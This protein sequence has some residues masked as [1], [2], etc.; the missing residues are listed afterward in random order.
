MCRRICVWHSVEPVRAKEMALQILKINFFW[1]LKIKFSCR[2]GRLTETCNFHRRLFVWCGFLTHDILFHGNKFPNPHDH[3]HCP[4]SLRHIVPYYRLK[5]YD[6][7]CFNCKCKC[8]F[9]RII[10]KLKIWIFGLYTHDKNL[11]LFFPVKK[12]KFR[13]QLPRHQIYYKKWD[14]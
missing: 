3:I 10:A 1:K 8:A 7:I 4:R 9:F 14:I 12:I 11:R 6:F 13:C 2:M 5:S